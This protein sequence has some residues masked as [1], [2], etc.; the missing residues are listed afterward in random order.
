[1]ETDPDRKMEKPTPSVQPEREDDSQGKAQS[2]ARAWLVKRGFDRLQL[3]E[4]G[5]ILRAKNEVSE[6]LVCLCEDGEA[7]REYLLSFDGAM[8]SIVRRHPESAPEVNFAAAVAFG[9]TLRGKKRSYRKALKKYSR[10]TIFLDL[11]IHLWLAH[12]DRSLQVIDPQ[13]AND[14]LQNLDRTIIE[15]KM[16][17]GSDK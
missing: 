17:I 1:M 2:A 3:S 11:G 5:D 12:D 16:Q 4:Q 6:W 13:Q 14:F 9:S 10:S 7:A 15:S 8:D